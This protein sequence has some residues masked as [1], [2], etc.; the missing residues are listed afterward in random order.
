MEV[1][2]HIMNSYCVNNNAENEVV[3]LLI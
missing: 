3:V 2:L 1:S